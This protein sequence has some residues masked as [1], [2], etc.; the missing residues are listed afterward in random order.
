MRPSFADVDAPR[1]CPCHMLDIALVEAF[2]VN[3]VF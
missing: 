3:F 2:L 1:P